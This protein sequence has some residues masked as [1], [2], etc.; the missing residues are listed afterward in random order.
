MLPIEALAPEDVLPIEA[1]APEEVLPIEALAPE[2]VLP[3]EALAP[4]G[5]PDGHLE[6]SAADQDPSLDAFERWLENLQ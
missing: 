1:L 6:E 2:E 3:I 4:D 5:T